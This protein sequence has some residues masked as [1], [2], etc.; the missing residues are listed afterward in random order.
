[1]ESGRRR[2]EA[3]YTL[4][5]L[6]YTLAVI[7]RPSLVGIAFLPLMIFHAFTI[8]V[9][10]PKV[11]SR[12]V[13][14]KEIGLLIINAIPYIYFFTPLILIPALAFLL[15]IVLSYTKSK[16]LPQLIGTLG[17][18][19]LYLPLVQIFGGIK[20]INIGA[21][22]VWATYVLT[23][24][25]YVEYKLPFRQ[26]SIKQIRISWIIC[27]LADA[28]SVIISPLFVLPLIE[29]TIRFMRPGDKL[30]VASQIRELGRK[31]AKK[32]LLVFFL[33]V[34]IILIHEV[35]L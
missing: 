7:S 26:V 23:E 6:T 34:A 19:L 14:I 5:A 16:V 30:K 9:V 4:V 33:L 18:A 3:A 27:L 15:S 29:P 21:Y 24:A 32:T 8:D 35:I 2:N 22:L 31:G 12:K 13:G 17:I 10:L 28:F 25:I 1:M 11:L 20:I